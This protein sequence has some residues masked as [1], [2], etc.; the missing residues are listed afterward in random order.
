MGSTLK[1][2]T[3]SRGVHGVPVIKVIQPTNLIIP[4]PNEDVD[5]KDELIASFLHTPS[6]AYPNDLFKVDSRFTSDEQGVRVTMISAIEEGQMFFTFKHAILNRLISYKN[7]VE[8]QKLENELK[9]ADDTSTRPMPFDYDKYIKIKEFFD[10]V[11]EQNYN[12]DP[13]NTPPTTRRDTIHV[14]GTSETTKNDFKIA[15]RP[16]M[17]YLADNHN[18]NVYATVDSESAML[19][20]GLQTISKD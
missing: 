5:I 10:W 1:I 19:I 20:E 6:M 12:G 17:V 11:W 15:S 18:S 9:S 7:L 13:V 4:N 8:I 16:L 2:S 14:E 3:S